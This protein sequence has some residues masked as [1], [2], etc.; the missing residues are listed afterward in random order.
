M[1]KRTT[2][3]TSLLVT[4][5]AIV[6]MV[7]AM[8]ADEPQEGTLPTVSD[9]F[10]DSVRNAITSTG[11]KRAEAQDGTIYYAK[12]VGIG[13]YIIDAELNDEDEAIYIW[14]NGN[15]TK[16]E[17]VEPDGEIDT[18]LEYE[19]ATYIRFKNGNCVNEIT[20]EE[21]GDIN[22][23]TDFDA[24]MKLRK[25]IKKDNDGRFADSNFT[26]D[27]IKAIVNIGLGN[28]FYYT[29]EKPKA[30]GD[31]KSAIYTDVSGNYIDGD[32]SLGK[33]GIVTTGAS[34]E[35]SGKE[36]ELESVFTNIKNTEDAYKIKGTVDGT[37]KTYVIK[38]AITSAGPKNNVPAGNPYNDQNGTMI[39]NYTKSGVVRTANLS[40]WIKESD[41]D[42]SE[43][44]NITDKV[45]FGSKSN[46]HLVPI[47]GTGRE[48][49]T[50][51]IQRIL[52]EKASD[53]I[54]GINYSK[55]VGTYFET[56]SDGD[57]YSSDEF[58]TDV[59]K[60]Y[61]TYG[62]EMDSSWNLIA[63]KA[64]TMNLKSK[65]GYNYIDLGDVD[66]VDVDDWGS[67]DW[68][69]YISYGC[70]SDRYYKTFDLY[71]GKFENKF[72]IDGSMNKVTSTMPTDV[73]VWNTDTKGYTITS[74]PT[75]SNV[76][77]EG[78]TGA[79]TTTDAAVK[80]GWLKNADGTWCNIKA[81]G[82]KATGWVKDGTEWYYLKT[83][84][85]MATGWQNIGGTWYYLNA[86]GA[87]QIGW[88]NDNRTWY[89]CNTSGEM[90]ANTTVDGF[91]LGANGA[92]VK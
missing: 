10:K 80:V 66:K 53:T 63:L 14:Q 81:D 13:K 85:I 2:K 75:Q 92:W 31:T 42:D 1:L 67:I 8:A 73:I 24:A 82:T 58:L 44:E 89:Y 36:V 23:I 47:K 61:C 9:S 74:T 38:A 5:A 57:E 59:I 22:E 91:V 19:G 21:Y 16:L 41:A 50:Q 55:E 17:N 78:T 51:V 49:Y 62:Y 35:I 65:A 15:F 87:M 69:G 27:P 52:R 45:E 12:E 4:A 43:Y 60:P 70:I 18:E 84:G 83:D 56:D 6:S 34:V 88:I 72:R 7:P 68:D 77:T 76:A 28:L 26:G 39:D 3:I 40:I 90:L 37:K 79:A 11:V 33:V 86:S 29:L 71:T 48:K 32:Y 20:G 54:D 25:K 46:H 64:Q 30:N